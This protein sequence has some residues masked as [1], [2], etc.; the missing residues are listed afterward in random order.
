MQRRFILTASVVLS[1]SP[2]SLAENTVC[3]KNDLW[4]S[5]GSRA[6]DAMR[7]TSDPIVAIE[8]ANEWA[9]RYGALYRVNAQKT[10]TPSDQDNLEILMGK[11]WGE[12]VGKYLDTEGLLLDAVLQKYMPTLAAM[13]SWGSKP[14]VVAMLTLLAP[15]P[16]AND[17]TE[18]RLLNEEINSLLAAK[19][20]NRT[21][22]TIKE[23]YPELFRKSMN[24]LKPGSLP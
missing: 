11:L 15:T 22:A 5:C 4:R 17:F 8:I 1:V 6:M 16:V 24:K 14:S 13:L 21:S 7:R 3:S 18:A 23:R 10:W 9:A 2:L 20:P 12:T 19:L